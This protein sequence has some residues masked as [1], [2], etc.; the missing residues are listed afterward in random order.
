ML[1]IILVIL[2]YAGV[3]IWGSVPYSIIVSRAKGVDL[4]KY[5][6]KNAGATNVYRALGIRYA[7]LVFFLDF[8]KGTLACLVTRYLFQ[9]PWHVVLAASAVIIGH[10]F[11]PFLRFKGGKGA[12]TGLGILIYLNPLIFPFA[13]FI[14][15][16]IIKT[17]HYVSL[18]TVSTTAFLIVIYNLPQNHA[19]LPYKI[20]VT[21]IGLF[22]IY[23]HKANIVRLLQGN[24][25]KV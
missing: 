17:T 16:I 18:A 22:V 20:F 21:A 6:S 3:Y 14:A 4:L 12:A 9:S 5:G 19:P 15:F 2:Y 23:K 8:L 10:S 24:E 7:A 13:A 11:S 1:N 25:K